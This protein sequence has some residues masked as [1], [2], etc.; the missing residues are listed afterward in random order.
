MIFSTPEWKLIERSSPLVGA[1]IRTLRANIANSSLDLHWLINFAE[2][3]K[4]MAARAE[5]GCPDYHYQ[6]NHIPTN[7]SK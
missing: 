5:K 7:W 4:K 2:A 1:E 3:V 6:K